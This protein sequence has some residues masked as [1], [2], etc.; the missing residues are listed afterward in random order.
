MA[1]MRRKE[2]SAELETRWEEHW[3]ESERRWR[4]NEE[5][6]RQRELAIK[7]WWEGREQESRRWWEENEKRWQLRDA[8]GQKR[9]ARHDER[10][11]E[12]SQFMREVNLRTEKVIQ[13]MVR[14]NEE[15]SVRAEQQTKAIL[16]EVR[17]TR[18][19]SKAFRE[20]LLA[21]IDRLPPAAAA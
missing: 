8:G 19:E 3:R 13:E 18:D 21:L 5:R 20:A 12:H 1:A 17:E 16:A 11:D 7:Q 4:E 9:E 6:W 15:A 14:R 10:L 2:L